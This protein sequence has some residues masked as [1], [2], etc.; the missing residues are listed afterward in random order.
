MQSWNA[1][2]LKVNQQEIE[3]EIYL[4]VETLRLS[5]EVP[6]GWNSIRDFGLAIAVTWNLSGGFRWWMEK[7]A[8]NLLTELSKFE[9]IVTYN[10]ERFDFIVLSAY[11]NIKPLLSKSFDVLAEIQHLVGFRVKLDRV[12]A[13]TLGIRKSGDGLQAVQLWRK[14]KIREVAD[15]CKDDVEIL[16]RL[17][18]YARDHGHIIVDG[19]PISVNWSP[20]RRPLTRSAAAAQ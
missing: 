18:A 1:E 4:D 3:P 14:G 13:E 17:V 8:G 10:G 2:P 7:D 12:A 20:L 9:R 6:G 5:H 19:A 11:G 15:Y 16:M